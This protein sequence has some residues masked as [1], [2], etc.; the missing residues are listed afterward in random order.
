MR[1]RALLS[2]RVG[3]WLTWIG[4]AGLV[5]IAATMPADWKVHRYVLVLTLPLAGVAATALVA[6]L[7]TSHTPVSWLLGLRPIAWFGRSLSYPLYLW[8]YLVIIVIAQVMHVPYARP[9]T[10]AVALALAVASYFLIERPFLRLKD[11]FEP[12]MA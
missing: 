3:A 10:I 4:I 1:G 6:G 12:R 8:H 2:P 9:V 11:R 7:V 5:L